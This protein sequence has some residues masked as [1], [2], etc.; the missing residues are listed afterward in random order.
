[1]IANIN[2]FHACKNVNMATDAK[3]GFIRGHIITQNILYIPAPSMQAL[4]SNSTGILIIKEEHIIIAMARA[5]A[6]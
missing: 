4:S 3:A 6:T 1:M 2:S 5:N